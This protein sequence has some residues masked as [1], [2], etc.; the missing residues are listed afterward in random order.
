[1]SARVDGLSEA[2]SQLWISFTVLSQILTPA[3]DAR[4]REVGLTH[5]EYGS[6]MALLE[7]PGRTLRIREMAERTYAPLPRM[8]KVVTRLEQRGL[9]TRSPSGSDARASEI[10]LTR[11][12]R[13]VLVN[14]L[15]AHADAARRLILDKLTAEQ[16]ETLASIL[17]PVVLELDPTGPLSHGSG[18]P[19][20]P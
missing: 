4:L 13:R 16:I 18:D 15:P 6:L 14:A 8:S 17:A 7:A 19:A 11:E 9:V 3:L 2:E 1:M 20:S 10:K 5:F 12:G